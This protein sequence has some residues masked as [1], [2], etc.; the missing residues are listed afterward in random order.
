MSLSEA[1]RKTSLL[2]T[3]SRQRYDKPAVT[4]HIISSV[5]G[6][7]ALIH[8]EVGDQSY[9]K[10]IDLLYNCIGIHRRH[11]VVIDEEPSLECDL[12]V[13]EWDGDGRNLRHVGRG[14]QVSDTRK[15]LGDK[16]PTQQHG[17]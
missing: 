7:K 17:R 5:A 2:I 11:K 9:L 13:A 6:F 10:Q 8:V 16:T 3:Q 12:F 15:T 1:G 4:V 14:K